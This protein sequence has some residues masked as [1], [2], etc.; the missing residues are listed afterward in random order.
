MVKIFNKFKNW[1]Y[2]FVESQRK[3]IYDQNLNDYYKHADELF[4]NKSSEV[5]GNFSFDGF[6]YIF[7]KMM[8]HSK[9]SI[10]IFTKNYDCIFNNE[11]FFI[12][13]ERI[14]NGLEVILIT[15]D[16]IEDE[17]FMTLSNKFEN[18]KYIPCS[19]TKDTPLNNFITID[20][21]MYWKEDI[22]FNRNSINDP[23]KAIVCFNDEPQCIRLNDLIFQIMEK[24]HVE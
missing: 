14:T 5:L 6:R 19:Q 17:R 23:I 9:K 22:L 3:K 2:S 15:Y 8:L 12:F 7:K 11:L 16:G 20:S 4:F 24:P 1:A 10:M 13:K 18:F 21:Y